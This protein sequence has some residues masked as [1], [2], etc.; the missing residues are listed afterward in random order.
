MILKQEFQEIFVCDESCY[1][2]H[3][4]RAIYSKHATYPSLVIWKVLTISKSAKGRKKELRRLISYLF[5]NFFPTKAKE[6]K[7]N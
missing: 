4:N 5:Q 3:H 1:T 6:G 7:V 2:I